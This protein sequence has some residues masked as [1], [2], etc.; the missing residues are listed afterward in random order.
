[1]RFTLDG[2]NVMADAGETLIEVAERHGVQVPRLCHSPGLEPAGNCR[3]CM[4]EVDGE[5]VLA[6]A[7]CRRP[8]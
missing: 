3:A 4:V 8:A 6:A 2:R 5:R 7:C 1:V